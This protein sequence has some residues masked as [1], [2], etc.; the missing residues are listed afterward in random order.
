VLREQLCFALHAATRAVT[1]CYRPLLDEIDLS[2]TQYL[3][4]LVLWEHRSVSFAFL[5]GQLYLDS[6]TLSPLLK[7]LRQ[8]GLIVHERPA[9]DERTVQITLTDQGASL[10]SHAA[11]AQQCVEQATGLER[12]ELEALREQL[13]A[14][15]DRLR[16]PALA[17]PHGAADPACP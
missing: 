10:Y 8:R 1:G 13:R 7:R 5:R 12:P 6:G 3:V 16:N 4:M 11:S 17:P 2:Y 14:L 15:A 9:G